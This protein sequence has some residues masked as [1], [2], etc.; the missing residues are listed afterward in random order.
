MV[1]FPKTG[2]DSEISDFVSSIRETS[3]KRGLLELAIAVVTCDDLEHPDNPVRISYRDHI[4][5]AAWIASHLAI[6]ASPDLDI[7]ENQ[8][9][10]ILYEICVDF[11]DDRKTTDI[12]H[13]MTLISADAVSPGFEC[14]CY[15][16][17]NEFDAG[18]CVMPDRELVSPRTFE[19]WLKTLLVVMDYQKCGV[20][21]EEELASGEPRDRYIKDLKHVKRILKKHLTPDYEGAIKHIEVALDKAVNCG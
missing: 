18:D 13:W 2:S 11:A 6:Q 3:G 5:R 16:W 10:Q 19:V 8:Y 7:S 15:E 20:Y 21:T 9:E 4:G 14:P 12:P 17:V 1:S